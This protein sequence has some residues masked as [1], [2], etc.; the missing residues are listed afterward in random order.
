MGF[1]K[2]NKGVIITEQ[3]SQALSTLGAQTAMFI[4]TKLAMEEDFRMLKAQIHVL[5]SGLD[6]ADAGKLL[7]GLADGN[8]TTT[9]IAE[10]ITANGPLNPN[11]VPEKDRAM[12]PVFWGGALAGDLATIKDLQTGGPVVEMKPR[13]TFQDGD[14]WNW[15]VYNQSATALTTGA[16]AFLIA[17]DYGVWVQ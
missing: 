8:L 16:T 5:V 17:K 13:W 10:C 15:F 9:Q 6:I 4:G 3:R 2:D 11:E 7:F 12:R 1:G 14:S